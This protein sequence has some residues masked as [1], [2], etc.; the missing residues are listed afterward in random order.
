MGLRRR[1]GRVA[2]GPRADGPPFQTHRTNLPRSR[3]PSERTV[4]AQVYRGGQ[5]YP[6]GYRRSATYGSR[7]QV[8]GSVTKTPLPCCRRITRR[9]SNRA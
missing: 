4:V 5:P 7:I 9:A 2:R 3:L 6:A 1:S 8:F